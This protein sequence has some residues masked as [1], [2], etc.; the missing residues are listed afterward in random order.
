MSVPA[1][2]TSVNHSG[3]KVLLWWIPTL[4]WLCVLA[5]FST[6]AF[7]AQHTGSVLLKIV[8]F[9]YGNISPHSFQELNFAVRKSAHFLSYGL[10]SAFAFFSW[11][12]TLPSLKPWSAWWSAL[13]LLLTLLAGSSDE[14]HQAFV[15]SRTSSSHDVMIDMTGAVFF[16]LVIAWAMQK[17]MLTAE[18]RRR[19]EKPEA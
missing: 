17:R 13:A 16:Q 2:E 3:R 19:V 5:L 7:S 9:F 8:H 15:A 18:T 1:L 10:L 12:V 14:I 6:D 11:R 4:V